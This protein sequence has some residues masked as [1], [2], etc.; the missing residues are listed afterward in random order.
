[1]TSPRSVGNWEKRGNVWWERSGCEAK[2]AL[3]VRSVLLQVSNDT[4]RRMHSIPV[5]S[6]IVCYYYETVDIFCA[7]DNASKKS[8][9][10]GVMVVSG[11]CWANVRRKAFVL[12]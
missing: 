6:S 5:N 1:M 2:I 4:G 11:H 10:A 3:A 8:S 12:G 9:L 7:R